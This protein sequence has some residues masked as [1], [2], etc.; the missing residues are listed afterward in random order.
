MVEKLKR[1]VEEKTILLVWVIMG[2]SSILTL[3]TTV[4]IIDRINMPDKFVRLERYQTDHARLESSYC[5]LESKIEAFSNKMDRNFET[6]ISI[7]LNEQIEV[8]K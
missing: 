5:R 7:R 1:I 4:L 3:A 6:L 2:L 8:K